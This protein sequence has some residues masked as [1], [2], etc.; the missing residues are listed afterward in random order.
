MIFNRPW[1]VFLLFIAGLMFSAVSWLRFGMAISLFNFLSELPL[2]ISPL[3][4]VVTGFVWGVAGV[5]VSV[6]MWIGHRKAPAALRIL[7]VTFA[8]YYWIDQLLVMTNEIR[9]TNWWF[10]VLVTGILVVLVFLS[11]LPP[12]VKDFFGEQHEQKK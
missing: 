3:Y 10:L 8:L 12:A 1:L 2:A 4:Q 7:V 5:W 9:S 11:L 6:W